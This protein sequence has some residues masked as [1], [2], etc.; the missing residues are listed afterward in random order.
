MD[1]GRLNAPVLVAGDRPTGRLHL[2]HWVGSLEERVALQDENRCYFLVADL[3][4]LTTHHD[5]AEEVRAFTLEVVLDWMSVGLDPKRSMFVLQ[6]QIPEVAE[7]AVVLSSLCSVPRARRVPALKETVPDLG[8]DENISL[9][10][11][12]YPILM[13]ADV[14]LFRADRVAVGE[15]QLG[16]VELV[17]ELARRFNHLYGPYFVEP[18]PVLGR[19]SRLVGTDGAAKM[20]KSRGNAI[21]L[22]DDRAT[23]ERRVHGMFT[24]PRRVRSDIPGQVE[25]NPVFI[26]HG[27]FNPDRAEV[28]DLRS[29]YR[30]GKVGDV[31]VKEKLARALNAFL[32]PIRERRRELESRKET[33]WEILWEGSR[34]A[35]RVANESLRSI[36]GHLPLAV[37][38]RSGGIFESNFAPHLREGT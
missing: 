25:D 33:L 16:H 13:A 34:Q 29:R 19:A 2:G 9:G 10:L 11:L 21:Y 15:D 6:S 28:E 20:S 22:S 7:L 31:E 32:D 26:Y 27:H 1:A 4:A 37:P 18:E 36:L 8:T 17:R 24:D 3:H 30:A 5:R 14:L 12:S 38:P 23:V 35:R